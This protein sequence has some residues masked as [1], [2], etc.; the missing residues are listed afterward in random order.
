[1]LCRINLP[2]YLSVYEYQ[3]DGDVKKVESQGSFWFESDIK[4]RR[5]WD[6]NLKISVLYPNKKTLDVPV[7]KS[8]YH[9]IVDGLCK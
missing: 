3:T 2:V 4:K 6:Y 1:M 9:A 8:Y 7:S 5:C